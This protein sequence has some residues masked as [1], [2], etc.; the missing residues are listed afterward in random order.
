MQRAICLIF[1]RLV[2][3]PSLF[4]LPSLPFIPICWAPL[5]ITPTLASIRFKSKGSSKSGTVT[6]GH[7]P[8]AVREYLQE[9]AMLQEYGKVLKNFAETIVRKLNL[10]VSPEMLYDIQIHNH[11]NLHL[12]EIAKF[13][14]QNKQV[15]LLDG[16]G[17]H[18]DSTLVIVDVSARPEL[19]LDVKASIMHF[20]EQIGLPRESLQSA[21]PTSFAVSIG[22]IVTRERR[23]E[24]IKHGKELLNHSKREMDKVYQKYDKLARGA[25]TSKASIKETDI[26]NAREY[27]KHCVK[28]YHERANI[29]WTKQ[30]A[31][32]SG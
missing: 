8:K 19:V 22:G 27:F 9:E 7:V 11:K 14:R 31:E 5:Y 6:A 15:E 4:F 3:S 24:M 1:G 32:L 10:R 25:I 26:F 12:G 13:V 28:E 16:V 18:T 2:R 23:Q 21:G 20:L 29:L 17:S 30:E